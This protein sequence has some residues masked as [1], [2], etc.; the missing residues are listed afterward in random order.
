MDC[1]YLGCLNEAK[2]QL[3]W[4]AWAVD[5]PKTSKPLNCCMNVVVRDEHLG[6]G[7]LPDLQG[8]QVADR[9][10]GIRHQRGAEIA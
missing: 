7:E 8:R 3:G 10:D 6:A 1:G 9:S 2:W 4:R 5:H